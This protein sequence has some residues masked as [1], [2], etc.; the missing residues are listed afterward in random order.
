MAVARRLKPVV[1]V[2]ECD[3]GPCEPVFHPD[4]PFVEDVLPLSE[5]PITSSAKM[6]PGRMLDASNARTFL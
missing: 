5:R 2:N 6:A 1:G 4:E 3:V